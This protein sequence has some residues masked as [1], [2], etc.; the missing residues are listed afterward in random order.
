M[1]GPFIIHKWQVEIPKMVYLVP[2][3]GVGKCMLL[4]YT[5]YN[6]ALIR[7]CELKNSY[8]VLWGHLFKN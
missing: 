3:R 8:N 5:C 1:Y 4:D 7:Q 6:A 2:R